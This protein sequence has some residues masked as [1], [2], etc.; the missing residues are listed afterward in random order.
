MLN[1]RYFLVLTG[2]EE[3]FVRPRKNIQNLKKLNEIYQIQKGSS[4]EYWLCQALFYRVCLKELLLL[5]SGVQKT[6]SLSGI[7]VE[8]GP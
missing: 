1:R 7:R 6:I 4:I 8:R 2:F 5:C 3:I